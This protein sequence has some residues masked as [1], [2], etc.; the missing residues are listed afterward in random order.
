MGASD[1]TII[2]RV[3]TE[4]DT[5]STTGLKLQLPT[6][7]P[8][9]GVLV[10]PMDGWT[11]TIKNTKLATPLNTDDGDITE[12]V[13]EIDWQ[14]STGGGIKPGFFGQF[15]IIAGKL[16]DGV[17]SLTF[18]AIQSYSD[19]SSVSWIEQAA[20]GSSAEPEHPAPVL[21]LAAASSSPA[22]A[23][24]H[25]SI[26][27][28]GQGDHRHRAGHHRHR[29]GRRC[30]GARAAAPSGPRLTRVVPGCRGGRSARDGGN[31][32]RRIGYRA[33]VEPRRAGRRRHRGRDLRLL[34]L[35]YGIDMGRATM[36]SALLGTFAA[37]V[38][39]GLL[40][41][42]VLAAQR[43]V[44]VL[45][46]SAISSDAVD[47]A[48]PVGHRR[49]GRGRARR[50]GLGDLALAV[51]SVGR[52]IAGTGQ[53]GLS[54]EGSKPGSSDSRLLGQGGRLADRTGRP[55]HL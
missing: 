37:V 10:A 52:A 55:A 19:G 12:V 31:R 22:A 54:M 23:V 43:V 36:A 14:A 41:I 47:K 49:G 40:G 35:A 29:A 38:D 42:L 33:L 5:A 21:Q 17:N 53:P 24:G 39:F 44:T 11:A 13:S 26:E 48:H 51:R 15:T 1:A 16:P 32:G 3:P 28:F 30:A 2:V 8:I 46:S 50:A 7:H 45:T 20:P 18:K 25:S 9:A 27:W 4:S 6:D 34:M